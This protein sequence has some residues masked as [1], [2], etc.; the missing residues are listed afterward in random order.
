M[1]AVLPWFE[2]FAWPD[3]PLFGL[4][5]VRGFGVMVVTSIMVGYQ[6][7]V[8]RARLRGLDEQVVSDFVFTTVF[9][10][11]VGS[12]L[13]DVFIYHPHKLAAD[14]WVVFKLWDGISSLGGWI[15]GLLGAW[16]FFRWHAAWR[17]RAWEFVDC[18][19]FAWPFAWFIARGGCALAHDH[20]GGPS[21]FFLAVDFPPNFIVQGHP[22]GPHHDLGLYEMILM[23]VPCTIFIAL[24][25]HERRRN[26]P[27]YFP[28]F[29][30]AFFMVMYAP[31]RFGL[32]YLRHANVDV[33]YFGLTPAQYMAVVML[34]TGATILWIQPQ[35][36]PPAPA[37][38]GKPGRKATA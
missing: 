31:V 37:P 26:G 24:R 34:V 17:P 20:A 36:V 19:G 33:R 12:H 38:S 13:V 29:Y 6:I 11:F 7:L 22:G 9:T 28:G 18:L 32:D 25:R 4:I 3:P 21:T 15:S 16:G 8:R 10:G 1:L 5:A 35:A 2:Q 14:P 27:L 23:I 30:L